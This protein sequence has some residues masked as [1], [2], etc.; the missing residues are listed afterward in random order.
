MQFYLQAGNAIHHSAPARDGA[1]TDKGF[2]LFGSDGITFGDLLDIVNPL[3][4]IPVISNIYRK[5]TG[6]TIDPAAM[7]AGG[8]LFGGPIGAAISLAMSVIEQRVNQGPDGKQPV[9]FNDNGEDKDA[10]QGTAI[11]QHTP[12]QSLISVPRRGGWIVNAAYASQDAFLKK[13][14]SQATENIVA[15]KDTDTPSGVAERDNWS[16][17]RRGGWIVNAAYGVVE[18]PHHTED[19][20]TPVNKHVVVSI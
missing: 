1:G 15:R 4:H 12:K 8:A 2:K 3:Q 14:V 11:V 20:Q 9:M 19:V 13:H 7:I 6:D 5:V 18:K 10:L 16:G 17:A